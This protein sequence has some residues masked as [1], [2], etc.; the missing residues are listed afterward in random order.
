MTSDTH[1]MVSAERDADDDRNDADTSSDIS[2]RVPG[3]ERGLKILTEFSPREPVLG[4]PELSKR[5]KIP[6]TT[7][8][9]LLQT[10][11]SLGFLERAD[12]DRNY[13][14]GVAVLRLGF[15]YLS[16][17][18]LTDL[19]LPI[20]EALRNDTGL[21]SHIVIR[22]GRDVVFVAKAQSHAP[23]FSSVKVNVGTRLPAHATTHGQV[24]MGDMTL[25]DLKKLYPEPELER[26]TKQTPA[27]IDDLYERIRDDAKRGYAVSE[28]SFERGISVVSAP[29]RND[30]GRIVAVITTTIP[31]HEIDASLLDSGLIDKVRRAADE[32]SQR[33]NFRPTGSANSGA[34]YFK[35]LGLK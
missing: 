21:T 29:V 4:A 18:E 10:L 6:R 16:S 19:G 23:I 28:S 25:D 7:V 14:L 12:K 1:D 17:L 24:L 2:Y 3:L 27:T 32:L 15:E 11:E 9:R 20:I 30:T 31:R 22:D 35:A 34:K 13:R 33:L 8:F 26:F 5:L